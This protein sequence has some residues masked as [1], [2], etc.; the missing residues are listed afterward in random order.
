MTLFRRSKPASLIADEQ[1]HHD[2]EQTYFLSRYGF[3]VDS[4]HS[5][6]IV[7]TILYHGPTETCWRYNNT[8]ERI[9]AITLK[10]VYK[11]SVAS[12]FITCIW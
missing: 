3:I 8:I 10:F 6:A 2:R 12:E 9:T 5:L 7:S 11:A 4:Q 1:I